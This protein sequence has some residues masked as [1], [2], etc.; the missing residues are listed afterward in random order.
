MEKVKEEDKSKIERLMDMLKRT[1]GRSRESLSQKIDEVLR[2]N[3]IK[4]GEK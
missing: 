3:K 2:K 4:M 1:S